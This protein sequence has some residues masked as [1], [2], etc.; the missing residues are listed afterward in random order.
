MIKKYTMMQ[1]RTHTLLILC[2]QFSIFNCLAQAPNSWTQK[3]NFPGVPRIGSVAFTIGTKAYVGTGQDS[4][5]NLLHD[6]WE[7]DFLTNAWSPLANFAGSARR[8]AVGFSIGNK[9]YIGT[10]YDSTGNVKDFWEYDPSSNS[11]VQKNNIGGNVNTNARKD[12]TA[13]AIGSKG[14]VIAGYDGTIY[15]NK[16]CWQYDGD[17]TWIKKVDLGN[18]GSSVSMGRRWASSFAFDTT[19]YVGCGFNYSQDWKKDFWRYNVNTNSWTQVADFGGTARSS[20]VAFS[21]NGKGFIG[22]GNDSYYRNDFWEYNPAS[23]TWIQ[24]ADYAGGAITG[25]IGF[26][27]DGIGFAGLGRD[28]IGFRNDLWAYTP[29]STIGINELSMQHFDVTVFPN[30][31]NKY[32]VCSWHL[33]VGSKVGLTIRDVTGKKMFSD[34]LKTSNLKCQTKIEVS[35]FPCGLYFLELLSGKE[36]VVKKFVKE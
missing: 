10:G 8:G 15:Y 6:F 31:V 34:Q 25:G 26:S 14:Y 11:W 23:N 32:V 22:T 5:G 18:T 33:P 24:V 19:A 12:A 2:F 27:L 13:F 28:S 7:Y 4:S 16:E 9:G 20:A 3:A 29:D 21:M 1:L 30:P 17:T 36:R 35:N